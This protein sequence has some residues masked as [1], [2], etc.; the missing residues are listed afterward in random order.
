MSQKGNLPEP[1]TTF[2]KIMKFKELINDPPPPDLTP[3]WGDVLYLRWTTLLNFEGLVIR[4]VFAGNFIDSKDD[5]IQ[6]ARIAALTVIDSLTFPK[7]VL[8]AQTMKAILVQKRVRTQTYHEQHRAAEC[9]FPDDEDSSEDHVLSVAVHRRGAEP[10]DDN[11]FEPSAEAED[12]LYALCREAGFWDGIVYLRG[13][14]KLNKRL[15]GAFRFLLTYRE[16]VFV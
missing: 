11:G 8:V 12:L 6:E 9:F 10:V 15:K 7:A 3:M 5:T 13:S 1:L 4:E 2:P 16:T 14:T